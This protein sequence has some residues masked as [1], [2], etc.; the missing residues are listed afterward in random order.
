MDTFILN[1]GVGNGEK[2]RIGRKR[3][4]PPGDFTH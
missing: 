3:Q 2:G 4:I 1:I